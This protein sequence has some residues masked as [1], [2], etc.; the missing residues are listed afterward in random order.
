MQN[1]R[2]IRDILISQ[3]DPTG[4]CNSAPSFLSVWA[5]FQGKL[6][7]SH[8]GSLTP[9]LRFRYGHLTIKAEKTVPKERTCC[10]PSL[11]I[12]QRLKQKGI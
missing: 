2:E 10:L 5:W 11:C 7:G 12:H 3:A 1:S 9:I 6:R 4:W 8:H